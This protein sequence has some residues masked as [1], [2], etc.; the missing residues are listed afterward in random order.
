MYMYRIIRK[1]ERLH[2]VFGLI[3]LE[4]SMSW[5]HKAPIDL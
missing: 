3:G 1:G 5:Q 2:M 4:L